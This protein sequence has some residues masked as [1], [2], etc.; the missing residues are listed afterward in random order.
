MLRK[1]ENNYLSENQKKKYGTLKTNS[2]IAKTNFFE[3]FLK[4]KILNFEQTMENTN[5]KG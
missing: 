4:Q 1:Y 5:I 2:Q 3:K